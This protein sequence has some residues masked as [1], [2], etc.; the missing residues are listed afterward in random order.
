MFDEKAFQDWYFEVA[1]KFNLDPNPDDP[2]HHYDYRAAYSA[3]AYP[4]ETGHWPSV[5]KSEDHPNR[6]VKLANGLIIDTIN[7]QPIPE[8]SFAAFMNP[9]GLYGRG[10]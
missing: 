9:V 3:G 10:H 7:M 5:Y 8:N 6:Y 1:R 4:D 2:R